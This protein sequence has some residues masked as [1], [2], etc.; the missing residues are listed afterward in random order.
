MLLNELAVADRQT[1]ESDDGAPIQF[2][3][4]G[5]GRHGKLAQHSG[6]VVFHFFQEILFDLFFGL[7]RTNREM[8][9]RHPVNEVALEHRRVTGDEPPSLLAGQRCGIR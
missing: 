9:G 8:G 1:F 6:M 7:R 5:L 4:L 2:R 3:W